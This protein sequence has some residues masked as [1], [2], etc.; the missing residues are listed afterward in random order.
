MGKKLEHCVFTEPS[1]QGSRID[2]LPS[3]VQL[4]RPMI[5]SMVAGVRPGQ[6]FRFEHMGANFAE[7]LACAKAKYDLVVLDTNPS[8]NLA[9]FLAVKHADYILA[10]VTSDRF[11]IRGI[12]LMREVFSTEFEWL[13]KEPWR[14]IPVINNVAGDRD[15]VRVR[16]QL[17][18]HAEAGF[19][20]E[21]LIEYVRYS[22]FL[23]YNE[24]KRGFAIDRKVGMMNSGQHRSMVA[25]LERAARE[26]GKKTGVL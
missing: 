20:E 25:N 21:A 19:G 23:A 26:L 10:P 7:L 12:A 22:G 24:R 11:S 8:G 4:I 6:A 16:D 13:R 1:A 18:A 9:T 17:K 5:A 14:L 2:V 15:A 3:H